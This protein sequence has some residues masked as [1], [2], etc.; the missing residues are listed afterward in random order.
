MANSPPLILIADDEPDNLLLLEELLQLE[1]YLT[2]SAESG[3]EALALAAQEHPDLIL[4]DVMMPEMDGFEVCRQ[5]RQDAEFQ[6]VPII[7]LTALGDDQS[8]LKG[9]E[10]MGDDYYVKPINSELLLAKIKSTLQLGQMRSQQSQQQCQIEADR[11][12]SAAWNVNLALSEKFRLFVPEQFLQRIAPQG[13]ESIQLGN[14]REETLTILFC[15]IRN[16]TA[17]AESQPAEVTFQW[18]N[19]FFTAMNQAISAN[20][21]FI[22]K[23]LGDAIM[24]V[25]DRPQS[26][27]QDALRAAIRMREN[28]AD[29]NAERDRGSLSQV[30]KIGV[31]IHTGQGIIGTLGSDRRMDPT[32]IGDV[33]NTASRLEDLTKKYG[34]PVIASGAAIATLKHPEHFHL[35]WIDRMAPRG[36]QAAVELHE[37]LGSQETCLDRAKLDSLALFQAGIEAWQQD[38]ASDA[39]DC[40]QKVVQQDPQDTVAALYVQRCWEKLGFVSPDNPADAG[41]TRGE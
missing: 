33:V 5:L 34:C 7:F 21:G 13:V 19:A 12:L 23:Y 38:R 20:Y 32:V 35:R 29:F 11:Q 39:L 6:T 15:D 16:F 9:I 10:L 8:R 37:L 28:L 30:V 22:D 14:A 26:H 2:L 4:L 41:W 27:T 40:F 24:A 18:L 31:G 17:I 36:K 1:G 25:F 3:Q